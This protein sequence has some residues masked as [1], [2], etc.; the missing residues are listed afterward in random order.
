MEDCDLLD[1]PWREAHEFGEPWV[2][3]WHEAQRQ[4]TPH[5]FM[6]H[7]HLIT[8]MI[9]DDHTRGWLRSHFSDLAEVARYILPDWVQEDDLQTCGWFIHFEH[10]ATLVRVRVL[11]RLSTSRVFSAYPDRHG[12]PHR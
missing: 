7:P 1:P 11:V 3:L 12:T 9:E 2:R 5:G 4:M 6:P 10:G 8:R